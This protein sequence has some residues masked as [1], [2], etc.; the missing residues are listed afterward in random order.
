M[1]MM[2]LIAFTAVDMKEDISTLFIV[3][4][5]LLMAIIQVIYQLYYFMHM[6]Q[7]GHEVVSI[8]IYSGVLA[9]FVIVLSFLTI[10]RL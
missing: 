4:I 5:I 3:P 2:T 1:I 10:V 8:F 9:A 6:K 7:S